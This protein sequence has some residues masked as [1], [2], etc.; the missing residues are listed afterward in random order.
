MQSPTNQ[1]APPA[2]GLKEASRAWKPICVGNWL[3]L[4]THDWADTLMRVFSGGIFTETNTFCPIPTAASDFVTSRRS[5]LQHGAGYD[6]IGLWQR[7]TEALGG[8]FVRSLMAFAQPSGVTVRSHYEQLRDELLADLRASLSI[9]V[10]LLNLH[11]AMI[12]DG[13]DD[14]EQDILSRVRDIV[15]PKATVGV[16]F[17]LH[18]NL[19]EQKIAA[20]DAV[21]TYKEYP[22]TD[23]HDRGTELFTLATG[24]WRGLYKPTKALF[25]C[26]MVGLYPTSHGPAQD[27]VTRM[28]LAEEQDGV[29]SISFAHGFPFAD[30]ANLGA[31]I[32]VITDSDSLLAQQLANDL[33][34]AI[35]RQRDAIGFDAISLPLE[36]ALTRALESR[37]R[38]VIVADQSDNVGGGAPGDATFALSWL[39]SHN[40]SDVAM[41]IFYDPEVVKVARKVPRGAKIK[42]R[43]GGKIS[44]E[45]GNPVDLEA[46]VLTTIDDYAHS[47]PQRSGEPWL[48]SAGHIAALRADGINIIVSTERCQCFSPSVF[49]HCGIDIRT[50]RLVIPKSCQHFYDAFAPVAAEII[51]MSSPGAVTPDPRQLPYR[52][53]DTT[54][55]YPWVTDPLQ[56]T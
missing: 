40:I 10:V 5:P 46:E 41:G 47:F 16:L 30:V 33:G 17:D 18:C 54:N 24:V 11:G 20:A 29:L 25:D 50:M 34:R 13:Y 1:E 8:S 45:S 26:R 4:T 56:G 21:I 7:H 9:D 52:Y 42:L 3:G 49:E 51:Y 37:E 35:Y 53:A 36:I 39:R 48:F 22:H 27:F 6:V 38:P 28:R 19:S 32:L 44:R 55:L 2:S 14:C 43:L 23:L 31:K 12:A 15:G